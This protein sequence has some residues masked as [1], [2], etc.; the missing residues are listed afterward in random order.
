MV[1]E[2]GQRFDPETDRVLLFSD[3]GPTTNVIRGPFPPALLNGQAK[4]GP[5]ELR[6]GV[7]YRFRVIG[8]TGDL[9]SSL[10]ITRGGTPIEWRAVAK[11]GAD[12]PA[13]QAVMRPARL[14]FD[15]GEIYDFQYTPRAAGELTLAY[16]PPAALKL[17]GSTL[18]AVPVHVRARPQ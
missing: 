15:P 7:T 3:G 12:L 14:V 8:L 9:P 5:I 17:P 18:T 6:A 10:A 16:G 1:L 2:P 4:P 11:D 13:N